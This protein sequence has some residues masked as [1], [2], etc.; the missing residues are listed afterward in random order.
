M[1]NFT[2]LV[3]N[4]LQ[5][6]KKKVIMALSNIAT[7]FFFIIL[8]IIST[9]ALAFDDSCDSNSKGGNSDL[10]VIHIY[11]KCSPFNTPKPSSSWI[12]NVINMASKDPQRLSYLSSLVVSKKPTI[13][14]IAPGQQLFN[15]GNDDD[16]YFTLFSKET[17][18]FQ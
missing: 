1:F 3:V 14:P 10:S 7:Y 5:N 9:S 4:C 15:I 16:K 2:T 13:V 11:G 18:S 6:F 8:L 12:N 17:S